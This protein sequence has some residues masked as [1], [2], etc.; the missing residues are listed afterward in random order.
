MHL[1]ESARHAA[2]AADAALLALNMSQ[3]LSQKEEEKAMY[4]TET[5]ARHAIT[6]AES[7]AR[8]LSLTQ[9][10]HSTQADYSARLAETEAGLEDVKEMHLLESARH[11][12]TAT[13]AA[14]LAMDMTQEFTLKDDEHA[15]RLAETE[16][17]YATFETEKTN[18]IM[19]LTQQLNAKETQDLI[20]L[21]E[22]EAL[23]EDVKEQSRLEDA[24]HATTA[25]TAAAQLAVITT[26]TELLQQ[27]LDG[28]KRDNEFLKHERATPTPS[29]YADD[30]SG[31]RYAL[32]ASSSRAT[33]TSG[34]DDFKSPKGIDDVRAVA[35]GCEDKLRLHLDAAADGIAA[36]F[37]REYER[38]E[39]L[40]STAKRYRSERDAA[41]FEIDAERRRADS[42]AVAADKALAKVGAERDDALER[43]AI[44][45][46]RIAMLE[47]GFAREYS[48]HS[49]HY[50][51]ASAVAAANAA[52][53]AALAEARGL[54]SDLEIARH[55][56]K[57]A[58][59]VARTAE[60]QYLAIRNNDALSDNDSISSRQF[61]FESLERALAKAESAR[62]K[63]ERAASEANARVAVLE[64]KAAR[65]ANRCEKLEAHAAE[66]LSQL[67]YTERARLSLSTGKHSSKSL[68]SVSTSTELIAKTPNSFD[69]ES[70]RA[71]I[72]RQTKDSFHA[73]TREQLRALRI[74]NNTLRTQRDDLA[75]DVAHLKTELSRTRLV[76]HGLEW[77]TSHNNNAVTTTS[78]TL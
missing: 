19:T 74:E 34:K 29:S 32:R 26:E 21:A 40:K 47:D 71:I 5:E 20:H 23:L 50:K 44:A 39:A 55:A 53:V 37:E 67:A 61:Q 38:Y 30:D 28:L 36:A 52:A 59:Q 72:Q 16:A 48:D 78:T 68:K 2:A 15:I 9:Q 46:E 58:E 27:A 56:Q 11:A 3:E 49:N 6:E 14:I 65:E 73:I 51:V 57:E 54:S 22:A 7:A 1:L 60:A 76:L 8:V 42:S 17:R 66:M 33:T 62:T 10:L 24:R 31:M 4:L 75:D 12:D 64:A 25:A 77:Y 35:L 43:C 45:E 63:A 18:Q 69:S 13:E 70:N 41:R